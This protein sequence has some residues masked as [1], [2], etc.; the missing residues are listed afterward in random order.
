M[1]QDLERGFGRA[2]ELLNFE[3][4][5]GVHVSN[6]HAGDFVIFNDRVQM[7]APGGLLNFVENLAIR[8]IFEC[9]S[10]AVSYDKLQQ[11]TLRKA[12]WRPERCPP[13]RQTML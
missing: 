6:N 1:S 2:N 12:W 13:S 9:F 8:T 7:I 11:V 10:A 4:V 3:C 5:I